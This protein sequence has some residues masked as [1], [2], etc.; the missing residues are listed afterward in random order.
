MKKNNR[1][2]YLKIWMD[3]L[4]GKKQID[5]KALADFLAN[6]LKGALSSGTMKRYT[7]TV[8]ANLYENGL[9]AGKTGK[10]FTGEPLEIVQEITLPVLDKSLTQ[11]YKKV[12]FSDIDQ[13]AQAVE[14]ESQPPARKVKK[15]TLK[16]AAQPKAAAKKTPEQKPGPAKKK[17]ERKPKKEI[18]AKVAKK[19]RRKPATQKPA[20]IGRKANLLK[21]GEGAFLYSMKLSQRVEDLE[22]EIANYEKVFDAVRRLFSREMGEL[23]EWVEMLLK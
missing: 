18:A 15:Q 20:T 13:P 9:L 4:K 16:K 11:N 7:A 3:Y 8:I 19:P 22:K 17:I 23:E 12:K 2:Q 1:E 10:T 14:P 21:M 5:S 6:K